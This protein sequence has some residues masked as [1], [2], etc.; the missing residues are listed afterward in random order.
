MWRVLRQ[1]VSLLHRSCLPT[2]SL[3]PL[4]G[5]GLCQ[6]ARKMPRLRGA[7]ASGRVT[8]PDGAGRGECR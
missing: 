6:K 1:Q 5:R 7:D 3:F 8:A 4:A 2:A